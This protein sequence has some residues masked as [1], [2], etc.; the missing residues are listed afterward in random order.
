MFKDKELFLLKAF[1]FLVPYS[2]GAGWIS[3]FRLLFV[4]DLFLFAL[5]FYWLFIKG[6]SQKGRIYTGNG[7]TPAILLLVW[8]VITVTM[9]ISL[10]I[11]GIGIYFLLKACLFY[12]YIINRVV[13]PRRIKVVVDYLLIG[14]LIQAVI[15]LAQKVKG[16]PL[17]LDKLGESMSSMVSDISRVVGTHFG[18][19]RYAAHLIL[20]IPLAISLFTFVKTKRYK[21]YYGTI[22]LLSIGGLFF[23][24]SRSSWVGLIVSIFCIVLVLA[25][26]GKISIKLL[27]TIMIIVVLILIIGAVFWNIIEQR[28]ERGG[29]SEER[30]KMIGIAF[31][32]LQEHPIFG[33]GLFNYQFHSYQLFAF[34]HPVHNEYL[35]LACET[36][37]PGVLIFLWFVFYHIREAFRATKIKDP[38]LNAIAFGALGG[39]VA[40]LVA[41]LMGPEYQHYRI[42]LIFWILCGLA[43]SINRIRRYQMMELIR[44]KQQSYENTNGQ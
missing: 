31:Q 9:A 34:W 30:M 8:S 40:L 2:L 19:N 29:G 20:L 6:A 21:Y 12:F 11:G 14:L 13:T 16:G 42:M 33:V 28:F 3:D 36:G 44:R 32:I 1:L 10:L 26:R 27:R 35:R 25:R 37:I 41:V 15:G 7:M 18:P 24:L 38:Y 17:G 43:V 23:S 4:S 5:I 22:V 39:M